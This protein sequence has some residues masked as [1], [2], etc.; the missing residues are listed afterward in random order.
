M[1]FVPKPIIY[2]CH[3]P[4]KSDRGYFIYPRFDADTYLKLKLE[5][6]FTP[7]VVLRAPWCEM[8]SF[9]KYPVHGTG[10]DTWGVFQPVYGEVNVLYI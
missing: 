8:V 6:P 3:M 9:T 10:I 5:P 1:C 7:K 4:V 2:P